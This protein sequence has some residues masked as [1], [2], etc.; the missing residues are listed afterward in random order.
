[1]LLLD[2]Q[3][4]LWWLDGS[5]QIGPQTRA[6]I[7]R[8]DA[9]VWVSAASAWEIAIKVALGRLDLGEPPDV[10]LPREAQRSGFRPLAVTLEHASAV[11]LLPSHHRDPFDRLLVVQAQMDGLTIVTTDLKIAKYDVPT[12]DPLR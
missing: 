2:T 12:L 1:M 4:W 8:V 7:G 9:P 5:D 11:G 6:A 3:V 10:C